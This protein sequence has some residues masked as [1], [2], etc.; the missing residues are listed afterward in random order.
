MC[1]RD[2]I[3][4]LTARA[5]RGFDVEPRVAMLSFSNF[6][7]VNHPRT[8]LVRRA[9][10]L[11]RQR[12]PGLTIDGEMQAI[13]ALSEDQLNTFFPFNTL[14]K[15]ANVLIFPSLEAGNIAYKLVQRLANADVVGPILVGMARPVHV[16]QRSDEVKDIVN[17]ASIAV[18]DAQRRGRHGG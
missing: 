8:E 10:D 17:L 5:A 2:R 16:V 7:S 13:V 4:I 11:V 14:R 9:T 3:A 18:V 15:E 1:I 6:G 12:E